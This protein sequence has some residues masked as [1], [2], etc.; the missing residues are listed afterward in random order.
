ML[1][2]EY[3]PP[4]YRAIVIAGVIFVIILALFWLLSDTVKFVGAPFL[5]LP[6]KLGIV[7]Q[8]SSTEIQ[9]INLAFTPTIITLAQPGRYMVFTGD[10]KLLQLNAASNDRIAPW[11]SM[12]AFDTNTPVTV[13]Q[14]ARGLRPYD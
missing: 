12:R 10:N 6:D 1:S 9:A 13:T 4:Q 5:Y 3:H 14:V 7:R 2:Q 8:V 11:L